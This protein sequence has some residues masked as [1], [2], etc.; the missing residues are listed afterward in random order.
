VS[1]TAERTASAGFF[2]ASPI[3]Y[4]T[5]LTDGRASTG[6]VVI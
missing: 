4:G 2:I 1:S 3:V 5:R 6:F